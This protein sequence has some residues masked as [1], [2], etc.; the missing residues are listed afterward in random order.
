VQKNTGWRTR[1]ILP[2][3][4]TASA[5][6][7][8]VRSV[9]RSGQ[10]HHLC[11]SCTTMC[12][13]GQDSEEASGP[14]TGLGRVA[15][16]SSPA[17]AR[18]SAQKRPSTRACTRSAQR[19]R[20]EREGASFSREEGGKE[21]RERKRLEQPGGNNVRNCWHAWV[22][23]GGGNEIVSFLAGTGRLKMP[24]KMPIKMEPR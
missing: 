4:S 1:K 11:T 6:L 18:A 10:R 2:A 19:A 5:R 9:A 21:K 14:R 20:A 12:V 7:V 15:R 3:G 23:Q 17:S 22:A 13:S 24:I 16:G 8:A